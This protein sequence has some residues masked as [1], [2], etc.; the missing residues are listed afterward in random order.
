M[1]QNQAAFAKRWFP[2]PWRDRADFTRTSCQALTNA[3]AVSTVSR[4]R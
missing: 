2:L 4:S 3:E 1:P